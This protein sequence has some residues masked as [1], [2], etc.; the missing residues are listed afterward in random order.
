MN[1]FPHNIIYPFKP[2]LDYFF[3]LFLNKNSK[4]AI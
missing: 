4:E 2:F 3:L 1:N